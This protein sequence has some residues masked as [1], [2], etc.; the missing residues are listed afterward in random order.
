MLKSFNSINNFNCEGVIYAFSI[1]NEG[2][3]YS[4]KNIDDFRYFINMNKDRKYRNRI[5][6]KQL[7]IR[8]SGTLNVTGSPLFFVAVCISVKSGD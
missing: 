4:M 2:M 8:V 6:G 3:I 1:S 7:K 5:S